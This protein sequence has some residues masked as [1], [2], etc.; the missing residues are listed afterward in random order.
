MFAVLFVQVS[1]GFPVGADYFENVPLAMFTLLLRGTLPD[2]ADMCIKIADS[3][4]FLGIIFMFY[5]LIASL[6]VMNMMIGIFVNVVEVV[7]AVEKEQLLVSI[8]RSKMLDMLDD[9]DGNL[10]TTYLDQDEFAELLLDPEAAMFLSEI[11]VDVVGLVDYVDVFFKDPNGG[12]KPG[13]MAYGE[14]LE[15][16][17]QLRGTNRATVKDLIDLRKIVV[18]EIRS[19]QTVLNPLMARAPQSSEAIRKR[20]GDA[21]S[22]RASLTPIQNIRKSAL[23]SANTSAQ[24]VCTSES[25]LWGTGFC[26]CTFRVVVEQLIMIVEESPYETFATILND[27]F[28]K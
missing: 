9:D 1:E 11:G 7:A 25:T 16:I 13:T 22:S 4:P 26:E 6:T 12:D 23:G 21:K 24:H 17:L 8:V 27:I 5:V 10:Q 28:R 19:L 2:L 18:S 15:L 3:S 14:F 20:P